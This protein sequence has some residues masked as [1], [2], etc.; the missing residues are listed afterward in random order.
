VDLE[1]SVC[2]RCAHAVFPPRLACS[3]CHAT[4]W[5]QRVAGA[6]HVELVT[7]VRRSPVLA[8]SGG[9]PI[10]LALVR[11]DLGPTVIARLQE[12]AAPGAAV[13][14]SAREGAVLARPLPAARDEPRAPTPE[15]PT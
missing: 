14:L 10:H 4:E 1:V 3:R 13:A 15:E 2:A 11:T 7:V 8:A 9:D 5:E 6:G 12:P